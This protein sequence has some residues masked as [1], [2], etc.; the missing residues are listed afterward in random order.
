MVE[1]GLRFATIALAA[2]CV[3]VNAGDRRIVRS[4]QPAAATRD[5]RFAALRFPN[6]GLVA[7]PGRLADIRLAYA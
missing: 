5:R 7:A 2:S 3:V 6:G 1:A 4:A